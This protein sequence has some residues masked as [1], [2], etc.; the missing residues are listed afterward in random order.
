MVAEIWSGADSNPKI[1]ALLT[2]NHNLEY[3][4]E[5]TLASVPTTTGSLVTVRGS[6]A[7]RAVKTP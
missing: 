2:G 7:G 3:S 4:Y 1:A 6:L 5:I